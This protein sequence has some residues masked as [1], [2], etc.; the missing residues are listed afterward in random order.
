MTHIKNSKECNRTFYDLTL[1]TEFISLVR[2]YIRN[3]LVSKIR[4]THIK[5]S[6]ECN[7]TFYDL[8]LNTEFI[9]LVR[10]YIRNI[11][12]VKILNS[13]PTQIPYS[14]PSH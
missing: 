12:L 11:S 3:I 5:K 4:M 8:T 13:C 9:S 7:R 6:K 2:Q 10:Q 14:T 1:N